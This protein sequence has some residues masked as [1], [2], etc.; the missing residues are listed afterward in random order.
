M[1]A[2]LPV[3]YKN[4]IERAPSETPE[5]KQILHLFGMNLLLD[6]FAPSLLEQAF[7]IIVISRLG[8]IK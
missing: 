2:L 8:L 4:A 6:S 1:Y 3:H 5:G 7:R